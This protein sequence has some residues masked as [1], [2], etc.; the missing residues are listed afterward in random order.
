MA[1]THAMTHTLVSAGAKV[2]ANESFTG[3]AKQSFEF[4]VADSVTDQFL[5]IDIDVSAI[6][7]IVITSDKAITLETNSSSA[8]DETIVL[9]ANRPL[10]WNAGSYYTNLLAT[11]ITAMY[12]TNASGATAT[13]KIEVLTD[14][15]P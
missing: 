5:E 15:T 1:F 7:N 6:K 14:P 13:V 3:D 12:F 4:T 10:L 2:Q 9:V 11:D 8:A